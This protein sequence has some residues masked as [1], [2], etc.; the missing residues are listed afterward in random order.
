MSEQQKIAWREIPLPMIL[1]AVLAAIR[2]CG[3]EVG[4]MLT[5]VDAETGQV[6]STT[7]LASKEA[8]DNLIY[9]LARNHASEAYDMDEFKP[10]TK[11]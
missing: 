2:E 5:I 7:N 8:V 4:A 11:Q 6:G 10:E 9:F 1:D 3:Y